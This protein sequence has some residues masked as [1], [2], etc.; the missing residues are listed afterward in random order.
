[1]V[2]SLLHK[3][4]ALEKTP[5]DE[6]KESL[7]NTAHKH[8]PVRAELIIKTP[9][10]AT[11][12]QNAIHTVERSVVCSRSRADPRAVRHHVTSFFRCRFKGPHQKSFMLVMHQ[13]HKQLQKAGK[14]ICT[15]WIIIIIWGF[16][17]FLCRSSDKLETVPLRKT[18]SI[19]MFEKS[20]TE[21]TSVTKRRAIDNKFVIEYNWKGCK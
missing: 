10:M 17:L 11:L 18:L 1:M 6:T 14:S 13:N 19:E 20:N 12:K 7:T 8:K 21:W 3:T 15:I 2:T 16:F 5:L 9:L 4:R